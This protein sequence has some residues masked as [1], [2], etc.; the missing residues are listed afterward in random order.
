[1]KIDLRNGDGDMKK[2]IFSFLLIFILTLSVSVTVNANDYSVNSENTGE[3]SYSKLKELFPDIPLKEN[4]YIEGSDSRFDKKTFSDSI[5][6]VIETYNANYENGE[7]WLN[8]YDNGTY[9]A[10]GAISVSVSVSP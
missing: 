3:I 10:Y 5:P 6:Q 4:G 2:K 7:C 9:G 1:M 8:I